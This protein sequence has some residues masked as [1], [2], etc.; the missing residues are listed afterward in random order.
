VAPCLEQVHVLKGEL[1]HESVCA[2]LQHACAYK[3]GSTKQRKQL[4]GLLILR[5]F[6][7]ILQHSLLQQ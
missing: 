4:I 2:E 3:D 5:K 1:H 6:P 7:G